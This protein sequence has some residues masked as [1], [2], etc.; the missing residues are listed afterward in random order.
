VNVILHLFIHIIQYRGN[1][2][3]NINAAQINNY[4]EQEMK[5]SQTRMIKRAT[6]CDIAIGTSFYGKT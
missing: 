4:L 2:W 6:R 3:C 5:E 1:I